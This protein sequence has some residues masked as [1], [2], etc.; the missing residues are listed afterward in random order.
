MIQNAKRLSWSVV[1]VASVFVSLNSIAAPPART[2]A[3]TPAPAATPQEPQVVKSV[4]VDRPN[5]GRDPFF[6]NSLRRGKT[7]QDTVVEPVANFNNI[8]LKGISGTAE[9]RLAIINNKTFEAGEDGELR[10]SG[11][12]TK[13]KIVEVREK[14]VVISLNGVTRELFLGSKL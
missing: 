12:L 3:A 5:F 7:V 4:F 10:I 8:V 11:H 6:P 1:M 9:K 13:I 14:S 2:P